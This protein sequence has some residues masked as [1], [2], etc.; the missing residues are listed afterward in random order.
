MDRRSQLRGTP[1]MM[2]GEKQAGKV[3]RRGFQL[4]PNVVGKVRRG[5]LRI[6]SFGEGRREAQRRRASGR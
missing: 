5:G 1:N 3:D 6:R 4:G 2:R